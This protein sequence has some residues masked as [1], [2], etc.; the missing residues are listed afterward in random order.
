L[1]EYAFRY[2]RR[3]MGNQQFRSILERASRKAS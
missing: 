2:N 3:F 1:N